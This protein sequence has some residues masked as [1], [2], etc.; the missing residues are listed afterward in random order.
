MYFDVADLASLEARGLFEATITHEMGH[1]L[2]F[3]TLWNF[4]RHLLVGS[5]SA[6]PRFIG[7]YA[8]HLYPL[9]GGPEG[10]IP[11]ENTGGPGTANAHWRE[12]VFVNELMTGFINL[13]RNPLSVVTAGSMRDLGYDAV[14]YAADPF[15]IPDSVDPSLRSLGGIDIA[16]GEELI[17]PTATIPSAPY[18]PALRDVVRAAPA[19]GRPALRF[20]RSAPR[21]PDHQRETTR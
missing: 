7:P 13:G 19:S 1:V 14:P 16:E 11:V 5:G 4:R 10:P 6:D 9:I 20:G 21:A 8:M 15:R 3:G 17:T 2:G 18:Q 12:S